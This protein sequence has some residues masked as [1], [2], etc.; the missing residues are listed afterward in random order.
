MRIVKFNIIYL[1]FFS[2]SIIPPDL[3]WEDVKSDHESVLNIL[4]I[5]STDSLSGIKGLPTVWSQVK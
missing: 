4:G 3:E 1:I 5:L 2:C